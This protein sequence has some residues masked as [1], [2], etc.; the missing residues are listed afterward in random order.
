MSKTNPPELG[1]RYGGAITVGL[2]IAIILMLMLPISQMLSEGLKSRDRLAD[3]TVIEPPDLFDEPP[4]PDEL[5]AEDEIEELEQER[6]PPTLEQLELAMNTDVSG[7]A[8]GDFSMPSY[9]LSGELDDLIYE[10]SQLTVAP[11]PIA[12]A[13]PIYP[14]ELRRN[15][16]SGEVRVTFVVR[17][18]GTTDQVR[19]IRS[20]NPGFEEPVLRAIRRWRFEPGEKDGKKVSAR[21][22]INIPF[23]TR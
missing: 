10:L 2:I 4:P 17:A 16:V 12:Q 20:S 7:L 19:I 3:I 1:E 22:S 9:D 8:G 13:E 11:R 14:P 15:K 6:E 18:D 5:E 23:N 21:V